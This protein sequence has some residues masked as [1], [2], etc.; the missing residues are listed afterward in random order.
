MVY[1]AIVVGAGPSGLTTAR[2]ISEGGF[3]VAIV[4]KER[5]LGLKPCG[6]AISRQGVQDALV[7][8]SNSFISQEIDC[9]SIVTPN[10][11]KFFIKG[12]SGVGY[13]LN[14]ALFTQYIAGRTS[15]SGVEVFMNQPVTE[16]TRQG[17]YFRIESGK[18]EWLTKII[19]GADGYSS[20][21]SRKLGL[22]RMGS[23]QFIPCL[24]YLMANCKLDDPQTVDFYLGRE[25][26]PLGYA[27]IFPKG[28]RF[29]NVGI[30][31][32]GNS[33]R[34]YL[35]RF[36]K[37]HP[38]IF[39]KAKIIGIEAAP[40]TVS[41]LL[42]DI[43]IDNGVLVGE[44]AG[45][46]IPLTGAGIHSSIVGGKIAGEEIVKALE[47]NELSKR[48]LIGYSERYNEHWGRRIRGSL[49]ALKVIEKL[50]DSDLNEL[51]SILEPKDVLDLANGF[52][53]GR[54]GRKLIKHPIFSF[55][56]ARALLSG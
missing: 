42:D 55:K 17:E 52:N 56:I 47:K 11:K 15:E 16:I 1:D 20:I 35:D 27:W 4:E 29:A 7:S 50:S 44:A 45:Q 6:E 13:I 28:H 18:G 53:I 25:V 24:Q 36:I 51:A 33:A 31:V 40:V 39:A 37:E 43:V 3:R 38:S 54:V 26:A 46:V 30:G 5:S 14:K 2:I 8:S 9:V 34:K 41:G 48:S 22:E 23:R 12:A 32:R 49:K 19:I 10:G 21:V